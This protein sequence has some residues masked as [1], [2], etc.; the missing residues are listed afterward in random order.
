LLD[1]DRDEVAFCGKN[2]HRPAG[3]FIRPSGDDFVSDH[4]SE[5]PDGR[6]GFCR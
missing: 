2:Q 5:Q 4:R 6:Y 3:A 1:I